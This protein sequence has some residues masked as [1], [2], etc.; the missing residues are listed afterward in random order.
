MPSVYTSYHHS[1]P[2]FL[3]HSYPRFSSNPNFQPKKR[4]FLPPPPFP[5]AISRDCQ[6]LS[7]ILESW[8]SSKLKA[9]LMCYSWGSRGAPCLG[10][11]FNL[12]LFLRHSSSS[13][14]MILLQLLHVSDKLDG[15]TKH[16]V[17]CKGTRRYCGRAYYS[18]IIDCQVK[19]SK[20]GVFTSTSEP[21]YW[22]ITLKP[23]YI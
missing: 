19:A 13:S 4:P 12:W 5:P 14:R 2:Y 9:L 7:P 11:L 16:T 17:C 10:P 1:Y 18:T 22:A 3:Y 8:L 21:E 20:E 23:N 15:T 6:T